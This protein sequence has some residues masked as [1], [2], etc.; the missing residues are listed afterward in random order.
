[1]IKASIAISVAALSLA[2]VW[3]VG[4]NSKS[5]VYVEPKD[6]AAIKAS[7]SKAISMDEVQ[8]LPCYCSGSLGK[9]YTF[10]CRPP[11]TN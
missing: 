7:N 1:M 5:D 10:Y 8:I 6:C 9:V 4:F 2:V 3:Y 11:V